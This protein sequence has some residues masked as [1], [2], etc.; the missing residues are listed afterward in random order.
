MECHIVARR[1]G[2]PRSRRISP[3][4]VDDYK[5]LILLCP[6]H[7]KLVDDQPKEYTV[8]ALRRIKRKHEDWVDETLEWRSQLPEALWTKLK[9][10]AEALQREHAESAPEEIGDLMDGLGTATV[11]LSDL[12][13]AD[14]MLLFIQAQPGGLSL[15]FRFRRGRVSFAFEEYDGF[16]EAMTSYLNAPVVEDRSDAVKSFEEEEREDKMAMFDLAGSLMVDLLRRAGGAEAILYAR[17]AVPAKG[18][19]L[20]FQAAGDKVAG[21]GGPTGTF[22]VAFDTF[23]RTRHVDLTMSI[24]ARMFATEYEQAM[25]EDNED[26]LLDFFANLFAVST[27]G[28]L[29]TNEAEV[30]DVTDEKDLLATFLRDRYFESLLMLKA[31]DQD[32]EDPKVRSWVEENMDPGPPDGLSAVLPN[33]C[34]T[35]VREFVDQSDAYEET[36]DELEDDAQMLLHNAISRWNK[37]E[38]GAGEE[39]EGEEWVEEIFLHRIEWWQTP[40]PRQAILDMTGSGGKI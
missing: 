2:G 3:K 24:R 26:I 23:D 27:L 25:E 36:E 18:P 5:N 1:K 40:K 22:R 31:A 17:P 21:A 35:A 13:F 34:S 4:E 10:H 28:A 32:L 8:K 30:P 20:A 6:Y 29:D 37:Y 12:L 33:A 16:D 15:A 38:K 11:L 7:H 14:E 19:E 39:S 9:E